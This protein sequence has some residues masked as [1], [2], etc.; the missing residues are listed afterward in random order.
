MISLKSFTGE[1]PRIPAHL[2]PDNAASYANNCDFSH[3]ELRP[4]KGVSALAPYGTAPNTINGMYTEDGLNFLTWNV[5]T[6]AVR[7][8]VLEDQFLRVYYTTPTDFR[9]TQRTQATPFDVTVTGG[10]PPATSFKAGVPKPTSVPT[11][12]VAAAAT[13]PD[14][15]V[16][17]WKFFYEANGIK[18]QEQV[19]TPTT[20]TLGREYS[21]TA[22]DI[23]ILDRAEAEEPPAVDTIIT[24]DAE[25][26]KAT[27]DNAL[28]VVEV[29]G[30]LPSGTQSF[31]VWSSNSTFAANNESEAMNGLVVTLSAATGGSAVTTVKFEYGKGFQ[32]TR[33]FVYT[34]LNLWNEESA[35]SEPL[36]VTHDI[37]QVP[38]LTLPAVVDTDYVP[39]SAFRVYGT[40]SNSAGD[41]D[42][43]LIDEV[44]TDGAQVTF[45]VETKPSTWTTLLATI[46]HLPPDA[47]LVNLLSLPGGIL[48]AIK[49]NEVHFSEPYKPWAWNPE[50]IIALPF[51]TK[52]AVLSGRSMVVTTTANPY[53]ITG[54]LPESMQETKLEALQAGA[55]KNGI[56]DCGG[57]VVY[58]T[59]DGLVTVEGG[60]AS[61]SMGQRFFTREDWRTRYPAS[62]LSTMRLAY[63]DG[64]LI[65]YNTSGYGDF[66]IRFDEATGS[67]SELTEM[68][69]QAGFILPQTDSFYVA[70]GTGIYQFGVGSAL[71]L[72]WY[73][74]DFNLP[75]SQNFGAIQVFGTGTIT[76]NV[77]ADGA[78]IHNSSFTNNETKRLPDGFKA[79]KWQ[80]RLTGTGTVREVHLAPTMRA[81]RNV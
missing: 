70:V 66:V 45:E 41:T 30:T 22:P 7:G 24:D 4:L 51:G 68:N 50:N 9:V 62:A 39:I 16:L 33:A 10:G 6:N 79:R 80:V 25:A 29:V 18:Y 19:I 32:Q 72:S 36:T 53:I 58:V 21:F 74:K 75:T 20:V 26:Y 46:G 15:V 13:L 34:V 54:S 69:A 35:P 52:G 8:P 56:C 77:Y 12:A 59:N 17:T 28:P 11:A 43:F 71:S 57:F 37:M 23:Q 2:L 1:F 64:C 40:V 67:M 27:P 78:L 63:Y 81:L 60:Q 42:Y 14:G 55:S 61:L 31:K 76:V 5:D 47:A 49:G 44:S 73:S 48:A 65:G 3:G 38:T